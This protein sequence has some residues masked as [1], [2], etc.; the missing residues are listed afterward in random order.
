MFHYPADSESIFWQ[1]VEPARCSSMPTRHSVV[2]W[3][4][5]W[6]PPS[7]ACVASKLPRAPS[8]WSPLP[9]ED[10]SCGNVA[11]ECSPNPQSS[12][13]HWATYIQEVRMHFLLPCPNQR[14][15]ISN[16]SI[17]FSTLTGSAYTEVQYKCIAERMDL[18]SSIRPA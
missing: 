8:Y 13:F 10:G 7:G 12:F 1:C 11:V 18:M 9:K 4:T 15:A 3:Y 16:L 5:R 2:V 14:K 17:S 6:I